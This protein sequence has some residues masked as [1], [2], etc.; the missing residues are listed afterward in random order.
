MDRWYA[1][2]R[3]LQPDFG[4]MTLHDVRN[5]GPMSE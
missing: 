3:F 5:S 1:F 4:P 2:C